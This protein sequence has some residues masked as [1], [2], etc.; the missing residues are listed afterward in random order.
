MLKNIELDINTAQDLFKNW[1]DCSTKKHKKRKKKKITQSIESEHS[2]EQDYKIQYKSKKKKRQHRDRDEELANSL[3]KFKFESASNSNI[4]KVQNPSKVIKKRK[5][6]KLE[7]YCNNAYKKNEAQTDSD[8]L[9]F[10]RAESEQ[11]KCSK[12]RI[13]FKS[14]KKSKKIKK[15]ETKEINKISKKIERIVFQE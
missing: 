14:K 7:K 2:S 12:L 6:S 5:K 8:Y 4:H 11:L 13:E 9:P 15:R 3:A 10:Q 1:V